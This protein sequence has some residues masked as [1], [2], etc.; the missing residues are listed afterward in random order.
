M[1]ECSWFL[2][3]HYAA[4]PT[5]SPLTPILNKNPFLVGP[6]PKHGESEKIRGLPSPPSVRVGTD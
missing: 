4:F 3:T 2:R 1:Q 6:L 5:I